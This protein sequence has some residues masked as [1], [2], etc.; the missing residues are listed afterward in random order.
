MDP[1]DIGLWVT[2]GLLLMVILG[3]RVASDGTLSRWCKDP[4][5]AL[6]RLCRTLAG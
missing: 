3:M 2:G 5:G 6:H 4:D 1:L